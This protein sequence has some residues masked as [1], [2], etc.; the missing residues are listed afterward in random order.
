M[1]RRCPRSPFP[2]LALTRYQDTLPIPSTA[3]SNT[4]SI[5]QAKQ[6]SIYQ[7]LR[8]YDN[9]SQTLDNSLLLDQQLE[10]LNYHKKVLE[11]RKMQELLRHHP[12]ESPIYQ[13]SGS[14]GQAAASAPRDN[15]V[16]YSHIMYEQYPNGAY[17]YPIQTTD[18]D[19]DD[20]DL[21]P[22]PS[23]VSSSYSEL[24][25]TINNAQLYNNTGNNGNGPSSVT[26][27]AAKDPNGLS[28]VQKK[29][30]LIQQ[31]QQQLLGSAPG[32]VHQHK[33]PLY[34]A[35]QAPQQ[36][37]LHHHHHHLPTAAHHPSPPQSTYSNYESI[38]EP[39]NPRPQPHQFQ[40]V[41]GGGGGSTYSSYSPY[42]P[43]SAASS[44][45]SAS[46]HYG[47]NHARPVE[48]EVDTLTDLLV[49]SLHTNVDSGG[50]SSIV[51]RSPSIS[52]GGMAPQQQQQQSSNSFDLS[53]DNFGNCVKCGGRIVG[54]NSG[55]TAM[56]QIYHIECFTCCQC[57]INLQGKPF[58]PIDNQ[59]FCEEDY[60][61]TLEKCSVCQQPI[62][63]RILRA[64][65]KPYHPQCFTCIVCSK[66]LDG[67]PFTVD[68]TNQIYC[69]EDFHK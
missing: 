14:G 1:F 61:N 43:S 2:A 3:H 48:H 12:D 33:Y 40:Q 19:E 50:G 28:E 27:G 26:G 60:L 41:S 45:Y 29:V 38:Y 69:I 4:L 21:P 49:R 55:C 15:S 17:R 25:R 59:P 31:Q 54:E 52:G 20:D 56:D 37:V 24:T 44:I 53:S 10:N 23:P 8:R 32:T 36:A 58:Y 46:Q 5:F 67:I 51:G 65:G 13:N 7:N 9:I 42:N 30:Q 22:A 57:Q 6:S 47:G 62:L 16:V 35:V 11:A 18:L 64:T 39:I 63:E 34:S 66:S 68:A